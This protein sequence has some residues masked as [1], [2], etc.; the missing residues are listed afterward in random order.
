MNPETVDTSKELRTFEKGIRAESDLASRDAMMDDRMQIL[1]AHPELAA[2]TT[3]PANDEFNYLVRRLEGMSD[4]DPQKA[5]VKSRQAELLAADNELAVANGEHVRLSEE[6]RKLASKGGDAWNGVEHNFNTLTEL[7][8]Q[9]TYNDYLYGAQSARALGNVQDVI[10]RLEAANALNPTT[11]VS[12]WLSNIEGSY[13]HVTMTLPRALRGNPDVFKPAIPPFAP[14]QRTA[15]DSAKTSLAETGSFSG[16]LP[17]GLYILN[18]ANILVEAG[19]D[20]DVNAP[21]VS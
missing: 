12:D 19:K 9:P 10:D 3:I 16:Y 14:D 7:G 6:M 20:L 13:G 2:S 1:K 8:V 17:A 5:L 18:G 4:D 15:I 21:G 11:E